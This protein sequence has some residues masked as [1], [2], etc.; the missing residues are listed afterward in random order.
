M[1]NCFW[2]PGTQEL[3]ELNGLIELIKLNGKS[4]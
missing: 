1:E 2:N 4:V 3:N